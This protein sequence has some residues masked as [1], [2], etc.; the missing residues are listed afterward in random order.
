MTRSNPGI[1]D[2]RHAGVAH[3]RDLASGADIVGDLLRPRFRRMIMVALQ[4]LGDLEMAQQL[5]GVARVFA[6][7]DIRFLQ[8]PQHAQRDVLEIARSA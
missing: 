6:V 8:H 5:E 2:H 7:D 1:A 4:R 3:K